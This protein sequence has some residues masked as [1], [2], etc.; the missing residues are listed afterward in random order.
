MSLLRLEAIELALGPRR[1][2]PIDLSVEP[3]EV[4]ALLGRNGAGKTSLLRVAAGIT[5][6]AAGLVRLRGETPDRRARARLCAYLPQGETAAET[7]LTVREL[8][9]LGRLPHLGD[10]GEPGPADARAIDRAVE[11]LGVGALLDR[12]VATLSAGERQRAHV[13][14]C[15]AQETPLLVL[16]EP[17]AALDPVHAADL[18][19]RVREHARNAEHGALVVVHDVLLAARYA[20]RVA[21]L[22]EGALVALGPPLEVLTPDVLER[23]LGLRAELGREADAFVL[24]VR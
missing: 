8:V 24:R 22:C 11:A 12:R 19:R 10:F 21:L 5:A 1:V 9:A 7:D 15:F 2:G 13:A 4:L 23:G 14:R 6:P 3:G 16:D 17:T 18:L 20:D